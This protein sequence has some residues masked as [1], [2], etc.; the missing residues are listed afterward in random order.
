MAKAIEGKMKNAA[1]MQRYFPPTK[2]PRLLGQYGK[3]AFGCP[4]TG[5]KGQKEA[6]EPF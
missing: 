4:D 6:F 3:L 5:T 1:P 2:P